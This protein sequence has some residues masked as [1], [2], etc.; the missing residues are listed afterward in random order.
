[1]AEGG[2]TRTEFSRFQRVRLIPVLCAAVCTLLS[3]VRAATSTQPQGYEQVSEEADRALARRDFAAAEPL[4]RRQIEMRPREFVP[5]YNLACALSNTA[6]PDEAGEWLVRATE[7]GFDDYRKLTR[8]PDLA[9]ARSSGSYAK[10]VRSWPKVLEAR[11]DANLEQVRRIFSHPDEGRDYTEVVDDKRRFVYRSAFDPAEFDKARKEIERLGDW[12]EK[13]LFPGLW[14]SREIEFDPWVIIVLPS[15]RDFTTWLVIT[16]GPAARTGFSTIGGSYIHDKKQ[17]VSQDLGSTFRHE[18]FHVLHW[19]DCTRKGRTDPYWVQEGLASLVEDVDTPGDGKPGLTP[20]PSWRTNIVLRR[21]RSNTLMPLDKFIAMPREKF[22]SAMQLAN[23]AQARAIFLYLY[24]R[25]KLQDWYNACG[26]AETAS[27]PGSMAGVFEEVLG[28]PIRAI[29]N[30][31]RA[32]V[33]TLPEVAEEIRP[34]MASLGV[35]VETG[36]GDGVTITSIADVIRPGVFDPI[37]VSTLK[38]VRGELHVGDVITAVG[39]QSTRDIADLIRVLGEKKPG[40][41]VIVTYR[42]RSQSGEALIRLVPRR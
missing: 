19:R 28:Q 39:G 11:R 10:L 17:L 30:D 38:G 16:F 21:D 40:D 22:L 15:R 32:W 7:N 23:Y 13:A 6:R 2:S 18:F 5:M 35:E 9:G 34:G 37:P 31:F 27:P 4:L 1:M 33:R 25:G 29:D 20:V 12:A 3:P 14:D 24:S 36:A 41:E 26:T 8:D 42:R